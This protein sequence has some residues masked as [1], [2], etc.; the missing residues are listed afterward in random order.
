MSQYKSVKTTLAAHHL[1]PSKR[2]GQNFL[3]HR[4]AAEAIVTAAGF[5]TGDQVIE[6]GVG[7]G[8]LTM[9]LAA[10]VAEVIGIEIDRGLIRYHEQEQTLPGNVTLVHG[11]ILRLDLTTLRGPDYGKLKMIANLPYSISNPF[12]FRI[13]EFREAIDQVTVM[14]QKEVADRLLAA[15]G[16]KAYGIPTVLLGCC[17]RIETL[18]TLKPDQFHPRPKIDSQ[19]IRIIFHDPQ[20]DQDAFAALRQ[21]VR[22]AFANRRKTILNNLLTSPLGRRA[23]DRP[24]KD[25]DAERRTRLCRAVESIGQSPSIRGEILTIKQFQ[26]LAIAIK[27]EFG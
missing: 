5:D 16:T 2:L 22:A 10:S 17:A 11:D 15:P 23:G 13:I 12:I 1:A 7:L 6:V 26:E 21:V 19:V 27:D 24:G 18:L 9:P 20:P 25:V 14:L 3:V 4:G 8:A